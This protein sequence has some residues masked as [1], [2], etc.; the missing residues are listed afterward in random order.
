MEAQCLPHGNKEFWEMGPSGQRALRKQREG[1]Q[2][3]SEVTGVGDSV[4][5]G[6]QVGSEG[7]PGLSVELGDGAGERAGG[8]AQ[9]ERGLGV[10]LAQHGHSVNKSPFLEQTQPLIGAAVVG[11]LELVAGA[12]P[13]PGASDSLMDPSLHFLPQTSLLCF[14]V[15]SSMTRKAKTVKSHSAASGMSLLLDA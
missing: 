4:H 12:S 1:I 7:S 2:G 11:A 13:E 9:N 15:P 6:G 5:L 8:P 3:T 14:L 10:C